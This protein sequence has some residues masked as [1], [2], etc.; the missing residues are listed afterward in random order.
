MDEDDTKLLNEDVIVSDESDDSENE[1]NVTISDSRSDEKCVIQCQKCQPLQVF[2]DICD[3]EHHIKVEH[4]LASVKKYST[5]LMIS[6]FRQLSIT[7]CQICQSV[8]IND[9]NIIDTHL[10]VA[11]ATSIADYKSRYP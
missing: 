7:E 10:R 5:K 3:F 8:I 9:R 6:P 4:S 1:D 2:D 11:H